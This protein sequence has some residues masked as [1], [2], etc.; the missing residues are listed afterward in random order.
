[1]DGLTK[2]Q[3]ERYLALI[4]EERLAYI[5]AEEGRLAG[6]MNAQYWDEGT[7]EYYI[8]HPLPDLNEELGE[9]GNPYDLTVEE[10][11]LLHTLKKRIERMGTYSYLDLYPVFPRDR[12][13]LD[14][15]S[16]V[17]TKLDLGM[18]LGDKEAEALEQGHEPFV[19][20]KSE[21]GVRVIM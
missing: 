10:L 8:F 18:E 1:M 9:M 20:Y 15:L 13:R 14:L 17:K 6:A 2:E 12:E 19:R 5:R 7:G 3:R 11:S 21:D 16:Q 4:E